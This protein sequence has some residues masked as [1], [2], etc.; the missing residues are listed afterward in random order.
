[1]R[2]FEGMAE[3]I[4]VND[5]AMGIV[6]SLVFGLIIV[7]VSSGK[8]FFL[9]RE[10]QG[11]FGA[12]GVSRVTTSAVVMSSISVLFMDYLISAVML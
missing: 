3:T 6:K 9:H 2:Y 10:K 12:E 4:L 11:A 1:M 8:G 7:W 5:V